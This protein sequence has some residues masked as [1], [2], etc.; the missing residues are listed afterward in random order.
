MTRIS[1]LGFQQI[2]LSGFQR[3]QEGAQTRQI[4]LSTG[5]VSNTY[6]GIGPQTNQLLSAESILTRTSAFE[7]AANAAL[8]R[9]Q[10]QETSVTSIADA[11]ADLRQTF[12][13]SLANG[14]GDVIE[15]DLETAA[16]RILAGLNAQFGGV[17]VFG[18]TD[19][20]QPPVA[21]S[22]FG[23]IAAAPDRDALFAGGER[24][25]LAVEEGVSVDGGPLASEIGARL[26][27]ELGDLADAQ[28][29]LGSFSG[30]L[31]AAQRDLLVEKIATF[32]AIAAELTRELGLNG[33]AQGQASEAIN[34][35]AA[36]RDLAEIVASEIEDA[37]LA[38]VV[39]RLNQDQL[40][41]QASAQAL[42]T[43]TQLSLLNFL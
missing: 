18:G 36:A 10:I 43:A 8:S 13:A 16:Q 27:A 40:A 24:T 6:G 28:A 19:G 38:E 30:E 33:V 9:L 2:L 37:D 32:D 7:N 23:D 39:A 1:D 35:G 26:L 41:I 3:A 21:A 5:K 14:S 12:I 25:R 11:V 31:S 17:F 29:T 34:R 22:S 42:S 15:P 4:Q 20:A